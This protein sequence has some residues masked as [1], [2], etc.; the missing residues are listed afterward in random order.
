[1]KTST[2][3]FI[4]TSF[5]ACHRWKD[6][7]SAVSFL[8]NYHRHIFYVK[9]EFEVT[10]DE[11]QLEFFMVRRAVDAFLKKEFVGRSFDYSCEHIAR[12]L[13]SYLSLEE[14]S[15]SVLSVEVNEDNE[16]GSVI[17]RSERV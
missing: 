7:P 17:Y 2:K 12:A 16:N 8:R 13:F 4:K 11:R 3:I 10:H 9:V 5:E 15:G 6:A 1:M 14:K